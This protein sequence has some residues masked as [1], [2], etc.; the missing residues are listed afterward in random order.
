MEIITPDQAKSLGF[1]YYFTGRPCKYGHIAER[2]VSNGDCLKCRLVRSREFRINNPQIVSAW[3]KK[4]AAA[5]QD[6]KRENYLVNREK[7]ISR[8]KKWKTANPA[9]AIAATRKW[10]KSNAK[11]Y[12]KYHK[13]RYAEKTDLILA[14]N[15]KWRLSNPEKVHSYRRNRHAKVQ[16]NGGS[17]T[18]EDII[19]IIKMQG[20]KCAY[21]SYCGT[22]VTSRNRHV[23][24]IIPISAGGSNN[25][26]NLQ[27]LCRSCNLTKAAK[28]PILYCQSLGWLL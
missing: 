20:N 26:S 3:S 21:F 18:G 19:D 11:R 14:I 4:W 2:R 10:Q 27:V 13:E 22:E 15:K 5:N 7:F 28:D 12:A 16:G 17:H 9:K 1:R 24:H 25:R 8:A 6:K 23:D